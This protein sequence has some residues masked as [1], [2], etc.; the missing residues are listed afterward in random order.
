MVHVHLCQYSSMAIMLCLRGYEHIFVCT[1]QHLKQ[2]H[3]FVCTLLAET[4]HRLCTTC[5]TILSARTLTSLPQKT[6]PPLL[7]EAHILLHR[8]I[9]HCWQI[10]HP[11]ATG[12]Q[13]STW[14]PPV[15]QSIQFTM[16]LSNARGLRPPASYSAGV[17]THSGSYG[18]DILVGTRN[19]IELLWYRDYYR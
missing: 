12:S 5:R 1:R 2:R 7:N 16:V 17:S 9:V 18:S 13:R 19:R 6:I 3:T 11:C 8:S 10:S 4:I 15:T 14:M